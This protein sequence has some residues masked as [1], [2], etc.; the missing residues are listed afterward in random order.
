[1]N[2][3]SAFIT[4][5]MIWWVVFFMVLPIGVVVEAKQ[6]VGNASSAPTES[7]IKKKLKYT[8]GI[9]TVIFVIVYIVISHGMLSFLFFD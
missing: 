7:N 1:M 3:V 4:F 9:S 5:S 6:Q 8:T 2:I